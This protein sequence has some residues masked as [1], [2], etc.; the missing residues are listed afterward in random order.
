MDGFNPIY[1]DNK[2]EDILYLGEVKRNSKNGRAVL[3]VKW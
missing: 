2:K 3:V 1:D